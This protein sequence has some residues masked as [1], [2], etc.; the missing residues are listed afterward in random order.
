MMHVSC[1]RFTERYFKDI[2]S[3]GECN[4][5]Y[6]DIRHRK[7]MTFTG[8][9]LSTLIVYNTGIER[10]IV[11][12]NSIEVEMSTIMIIDYFQNKNFLEIA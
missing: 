7:N 9:N 1:C 12:V 2:Y 8:T 11:G 5:K 10:I 4:L 3:L 6:H